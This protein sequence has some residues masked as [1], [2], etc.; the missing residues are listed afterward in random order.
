MALP[1]DFAGLI[2]MLIAGKKSLLAQQ[3]YDFTGLVRYAPPEL[4]IRATRPLPSD[5]TR[6]LGD[7]LKSLTHINWQ[8]MM[9]DEVAAP[10]LLDQAKQQ[11]D[12]A[13]NTVLSQ[14]MVVAAMA[15]FPDAEL[16]SYELSEQRS[17]TT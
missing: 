9:S 3:L 11:E 6:L 7:A 16:D 17:V 13:R 4:V 1:G 5:F 2:E 8:V 10:S 14:P 15:A 12:A